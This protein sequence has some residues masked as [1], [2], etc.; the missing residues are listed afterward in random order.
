MLLALQKKRRGG[1]AVQSWSRNDPKYEMQTKQNCGCCVCLLNLLWFAAH[2]QICACC[3][4]NAGKCCY[5]RL[6]YTVQISHFFISLRAAS[7][8]RLLR[9]VRLQL[10]QRHNGQRHP[11]SVLRHGQH[12]HCALYVSIETAEQRNLVH[13]CQGVYKNWHDGWIVTTYTV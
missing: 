2:D 1:V 12:R 4:C 5:R 8:P 6:L 9:D 3:W 13:S 10:E 11:G 7:R